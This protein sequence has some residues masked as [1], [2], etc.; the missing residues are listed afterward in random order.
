MACAAF[1]SCHLSITLFMEE[2]SLLEMG[3]SSQKWYQQIEVCLT[4]V[5]RLRTKAV[6]MFEP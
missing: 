2:D 1:N 5:D 6:V 3:C 4:S